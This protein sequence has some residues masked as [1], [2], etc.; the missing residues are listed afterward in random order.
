MP[1]SAGGTVNDSQFYT[2]DAT[3]RTALELDVPYASRRA[4]VRCRRAAVAAPDLRVAWDNR[5]GGGDTLLDNLLDSW[6]E[7]LPRLANYKRTPRRVPREPS[8]CNGRIAPE[9]RDPAQPGALHMQAFD[10][11]KPGLGPDLETIENGTI[12]DD[13]YPKKMALATWI[14]Y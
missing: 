5:I 14:P 3:G 7:D 2:R 12:P 1:M 6:H 11:P 8:L 10:K 4:A 13:R 9:A